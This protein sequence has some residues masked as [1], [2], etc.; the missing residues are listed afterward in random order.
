MLI[1]LLSLGTSLILV[2]V[3][4]WPCLKLYSTLH[5]LVSVGGNRE[6]I[7]QGPTL[8]GDCIAIYIG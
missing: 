1:H 4:I 7:S 5:H 3:P 6:I 8:P 2:N